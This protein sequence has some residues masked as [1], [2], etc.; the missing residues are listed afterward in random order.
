MALQRVFTSVVAATL[1]AATFASA[2]VAQNRIVQIINSSGYTIMEFYGSNIG[3]DSWEED[4][5]RYD[6]I[7]SGA[8]MNTNFDDG[9]GYCMFDFK[10]VFDNGDVQIRKRV[11]VCEIDTYTYN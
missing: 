11:N 10:A 4:F 7:P 3:S 5:L 2:A 1:I 8:H 9:S 6:M